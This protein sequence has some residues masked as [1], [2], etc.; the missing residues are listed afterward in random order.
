MSASSGIYTGAIQTS[1]SAF[2]QVEMPDSPPKAEKVVQHGDGVLSPLGD[3]IT[4]TVVYID[5]WPTSVTSI[6]RTAVSAGTIAFV[7]SPLLSTFITA[8]Q[9]IGVL[10]MKK[11]LDTSS[12]A[13][14]TIDIVVRSHSMMPTAHVAFNTSTNTSYNTTVL[15]LVDDTETVTLNETFVASGVFSGFFRAAA[16]LSGTFTDAAGVLLTNTSSLEAWYPESGAAEAEDGT[17]ADGRP[18]PSINVRMATDASSVSPKVH[19]ATPGAGE[20]LTITVVDPDADVRF[21][22]PDVVTVKVSSSKR[23]EGDERVLLT[24]TVANSRNLSSGGLQGVFTGV[25]KTRFTTAVSPPADGVIYVNQDDHLTVEYEEAVTM[26]GNTGVARSSQIIVSAPGEPA[27]VALSPHLLLE[28]GTLC[29]SL[30]NDLEP[31]T[32]PVALL[33]WETPRG[34]RRHVT[35]ELA[36]AAQALFA[37]AP[38]AMRHYQRCLSTTT[39]SEAAGVQPATYLGGNDPFKMWEMT[40]G[41]IVTVTYTDP[42]PFST[43]SDVAAVSRKGLLRVTP[44]VLGMGRTMSITVT[45]IDLN[46][47]ASVAEFASVNVTSSW[48]EE[49]LEQ[50]LLTENGVDSQEFTGLLRTILNSDPSPES[51]QRQNGCFEALSAHAALHVREGDH[52]TITYHDVCST[53]IEKER[54]ND[55]TVETRVG[56]TGKTFIYNCESACGGV[57]LGGDAVSLTVVD[58]DIAF[59]SGGGGGLASG[60]AGWLDWVDNSPAGTA[61][62]PVVVTTSKDA[63]QETIHLHAARNL[64][65]GT[66]TGVLDTCMGAEYCT[67]RDGVFTADDCLACSPSLQGESNNG[68]L[69]V[70]AGDHLSVSYQD[71][72]PHATRSHSIKVARIGVLR[73]S[74]SQR[75]ENGDQV[76]MTVIDSDANTNLQLPESLSVRVDSP[77]VGQPPQ[78]I[79]L[80]ENGDDTGHFTGVFTSCLTCESAEGLVQVEPGGFITC[81]Y[82]DAHVPA[83]AADGASIVKVVIAA[84]DTSITATPKVVLPGE[85]VSVEVINTDIRMSS[86]SVEVTVVKKPSADA[87]HE[88]L[89]LQQIT[90]QVQQAASQL[91]ARLLPDIVS[92]SRYKCS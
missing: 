77:V 64:E 8:N 83:D 52:V 22:Y 14:Q 35:V 68:V 46:Q 67:P 51:C 42:L 84:A 23:F 56:V 18:W 9:S 3:N 4:V 69:S 74:P 88:V 11:S 5:M 43:Y 48:A 54:N 82:E 34:Q 65:P 26:Q 12:T 41:T 28:N 53:S 10:L 31:L 7:P 16:S 92:A 33:S 85:P 27:R 17:G 70:R 80:L 15:G 2:W 1:A 39:A 24:E 13:S 49:S 87:E 63:E 72:M 29:V 21:G 61:V 32:V 57:V 91:A 81:T 58:A 59:E 86:D 79:T 38:S 6:L 36:N 19:S 45:D 25:I 55:I 75:V 78:P 50:V 47:D 60:L 20:R 44:L 30:M 71:L 89:I 66:F 73:L 37:E 76:A 62:I 90:H 40:R